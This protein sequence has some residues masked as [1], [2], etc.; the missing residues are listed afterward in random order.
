MYSGSLVQYFDVGIDDDLAGGINDH[1]ADGCAG[2]LSK[3]KFCGAEDQQEQKKGT[4]ASQEWTPQVNRNEVGS[5][6]LRM[7]F[8]EL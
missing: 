1:P 3:R 2:G 4:K 7:P 6:S 8:A 5:S